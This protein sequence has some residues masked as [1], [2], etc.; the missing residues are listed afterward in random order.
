MLNSN[1]KN[2]IKKN[3]KD[4]FLCV[5]IKN[6]FKLLKNKWKDRFRKPFTH[7]YSVREILMQQNR[8]NGFNRLDIIVRLLAVENEYG[9]NDYGWKLYE[10]MQSARVGTEERK[11]EDIVKTFRELICSWEN[12]GYDNASLI[13]LDENL[14]LDDGSHRLSLSLFHKIPEI[15]CQVLPF[16]CERDYGA[17]WFCE[18]GFTNEE[19]GLIEN[20]ANKILRENKIKIS[21]LLWPP[22][23]HY[24]DEITEILSEKYDVI[25]YHDMEFADETFERFVRAVYQIDDIDQWKIDTKIEY[26]RPWQRKLVRVV[27]V[28]FDYPVFRYKDM[29]QNTILTQGEELK[30]MIRGMYKDRI[31]NYFYDI[32]CH[33][34]DN[35]EQSE[36]IMRLCEPGFS[37]K[38]YF[39]EI[40]G[41]Y[42]MANS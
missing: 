33:T 25:G 22:V 26:M 17:D 21:C 41:G 2:L 14:K 35:S 29:N 32:I 11:L 15:N 39:D 13:W 16:A 34:G 30:A 5:K 7:M 20:R 8:I 36:Y 6:K 38:D 12:N 1:F 23:Q 18:N 42:R 37:L 40:G 4:Y 19:I 24:F 28:G 10:K 27:S 31:K 9:L 3:E